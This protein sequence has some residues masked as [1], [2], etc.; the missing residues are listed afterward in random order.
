[1]L[2][3]Q[4]EQTVPTTMSHRTRRP[5]TRS[6][7]ISAWVVPVL[8]I[9]QFAMVAIIPVALVLIGTLRNAHLHALRWWAAA[10]ATAY[11]T[12]LALWAIGPDRA[13][14]LS[15]DLSHALAGIIVAA[16]I[17]VALRYHLMRRKQS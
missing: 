5:A 16:G 9:G 11:G 14:S 8:I 13:P 4:Q 7:I 3:T 1:M 2:D 6:V 17:A 10:L 12:A 15:K